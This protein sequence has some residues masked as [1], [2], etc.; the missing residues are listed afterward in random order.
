MKYRLTFQCK[1]PVVLPVQYNR[2][3]QAALLYWL[4]EECASFLHNQGY[5]NEKKIQALYLL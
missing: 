5:E 4:G 3:L 1:N 2:I